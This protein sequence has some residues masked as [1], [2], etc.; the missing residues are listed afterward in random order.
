MPGIRMSHSTTSGR[1]ARTSC[2]PGPAVAGLTD[3]LEVVLGL[4]QR[5]QPH[6]DQ[7]LVV[8][9]RYPDHG[10]RH[11]HRAASPGPRSRRSCGPR[12]SAPPSALAPGRACPASPHALPGTSASRCPSS[13]TLTSSASPSTDDDV[14]RAAWRRCA[15][16]RWSAPPAR[17]RYA[18]RADVVG[19]RVGRLLRQIDLEPAGAHPRRPDRQVVEAVLD[20]A[21]A[22]SRRRRS[23]A[24]VSSARSASSDSRLVSRI[25]SSDSRA[26][27]GSRSSTCSATPA[28]IAITARPCPTPSCRSWAI[29]SRSSVAVRRACSRRSRSGSHRAP[30]PRHAAASTARNHAT[31]PATRRRPSPVRQRLASAAATGTTAPAVRPASD[32][33]ATAR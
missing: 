1:A 33:A 6:P 16:A 15:A 7:R 3:Q 26:F 12:P 14:D 8:D 10:A 25:A 11:R 9:H 27:A 31:R 23:P 2:E 18:A 29:R 24:G 21:G 32:A 30:R 20:G 19:H 4:D 22:P 5:A 28:C 13:T 17:S